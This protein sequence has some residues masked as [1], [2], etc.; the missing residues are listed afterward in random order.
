[1]ESVDVERRERREDEDDEERVL[2][3]PRGALSGSEIGESKLSNSAIAVGDAGSC[4]SRT[5]LFKVGVIS[6]GRKAG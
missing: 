3:R 4:I 6:V 5:S 2:E 1:M